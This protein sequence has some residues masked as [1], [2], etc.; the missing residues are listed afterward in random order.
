MKFGLFAVNMYACS[1]PET[2]I[3]VAKLAEEAGFE[4]LWA[5][6]HVVL[7][8]PRGPHSPMAP[9]DRILDPIVA[10]TYLAAHTSRVRL[11]TGIIILPQRN[12]LVLA[13]E[14]ASL[15]EL[16]GGRLICGVGVGYLESEFR[17]L[18]IPFSD[19]G[20]RTD[21]YLAAM[22]AIWTQP[23]PAY[24]GR[25]VSFEGVQAHPQRNIPVVVGGE[26][27]PA[28][29]RAVQRA[30]GWYG[31]NLDPNFTASALADIRKAMQDAARPQEL[32][33]LEISVTPAEPLTLE[34]VERFADL[35][36]H[37]L[38]V[39]PLH[40]MPL[41]S[42]DASAIKDYVTMVGDTFIGRF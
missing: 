12:P 13:K 17:A 18:G 36:V 34:D 33:E 41:Q 7:Q 9:H 20:I 25:F 15:D 21:E 8:S 24:H 5:G 23:N 30:T 28:Y 29:R 40:K 35:G 27:V 2:A 26:S 37:R 39:M 22:Q 10:L 31:F 6:E 11:G 1:Y 42:R 32:G 14:L 3:Q 19:R 16:S 4:S 38:I